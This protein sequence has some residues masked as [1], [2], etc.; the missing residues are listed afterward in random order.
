MNNLSNNIKKVIILYLLL[1]LATISGMVYF[2]IVQAGELE[3][4]SYN[5]RIW[6][7]REKVSRGTI[8]DSDNEV[9]AIT[10]D[11]GQRSYPYGAVFSHIVGYYRVNES[12]AGL[13][14][15]YDKYLR[16]DT[17]LGLSELFDKIDEALKGKNS[18][19]EFIVDEGYNIVTTLDASIQKRAYEELSGENGGNGAIVAIEP[20]TGKILA[21]VSYPSFNPLADTVRWQEY[22]NDDNNPLFNRAF[23]GLYPPGSTF[24]IV[25]LLSALENID[26]VEQKI[27][28]DDGGITFNDNES[29]SNFGGEV[30]GEI[31]LQ[32]AFTESSNDVFG[33]LGIELGNENLKNTAEQ[34]FFNKELNID[35]FSIN[36]SNF[37]TLSSWEKGDIAQ[38][39]IGQGQVIVSPAQMAIITSVIANDGIYKE[40]YIV[41]K[42]VN[43]D[44]YVI[45]DNTPSI[46]GDRI[47]SEKEVETTKEYMKKVVDEGT[48]TNAKISGV[49]VCG[50]TGTAE[51]GDKSS[52]HSWFV[53]FAP[54]EN[55]QIAVA[56][57]VEDGGLG[58]NRAAKI[59]KEVI[60]EA[61]K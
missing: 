6:I 44:G 11:N 43:D 12:I 55:P 22:N 48:G 5:K 50:K 52:S 24:K 53:A 46:S 61:L 14:K 1:F 28:E 58:G 32:K 4:S 15:E 60:I 33:E 51:Y 59:A 26:G 54:A 42:I 7:E 9:L 21:S 35:G 47:F 25:T 3:E 17:F 13:E 41:E 8:Y 45:K 39:A 34:L 29:I 23:S 40:P 18:D 20:Q 27:F 57:I 31:S 19:E 16:G 30:M 36:E 49:E 38:S 56:V 2:L 10:D 37:P